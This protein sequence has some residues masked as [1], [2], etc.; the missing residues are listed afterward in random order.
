MRYLSGHE[1]HDHSGMGSGLIFLGGI[2]AL[3]FPIFPL[4]FIFLLRDYVG[5]LLERLGSLIIS[6]YSESD[7]CI[8][9]AP[10][11]TNWIIIFITIG[12]IFTIILGIIS[13]Y[14]YTM[15]KRGKLRSG[16][17]LATV[18]GVGMFAT[19]HW[20]PGFITIIG[21]VLCYTSSKVPY[22]RIQ[23]EPKA[24]DEVWVPRS[25]E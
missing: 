1:I 6:N 10:H 2:L 14:A 21:G 4:A 9:I 25:I 18:A 16:G 22:P 11:L 7:F 24:S 17:L 23:D 13:I 12:A 20:I 3:I 15:V 8:N 19:I 5:V